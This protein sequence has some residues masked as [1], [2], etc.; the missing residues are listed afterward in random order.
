MSDK[1]N[2]LRDKKWVVMIEIIVGLTAISGYGIKDGISGII[3]YCN[4]EIEMIR[5]DAM[6]LFDNTANDTLAL[7]TPIRLFREVHEKM[8]KDET[9]YRLLLERANA[10]IWAKGYRY[11]RIAEKLLEEAIG[12]SERPYR[13]ENRLKGIRGLKP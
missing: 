10:I 9:G 2:N 4:Q 3:N 8:P 1:K 5:D 13:A 11:D 6:E 7:E 12:L